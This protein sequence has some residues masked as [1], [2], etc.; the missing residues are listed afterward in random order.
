MHLHR[1]VK[2]VL[3][4]SRQTPRRTNGL[5]VSAGPD[6]GRFVGYTGVS[7]TGFREINL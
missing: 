1:K 3:T 2:L 7:Q 4:Y 6:S 5:T